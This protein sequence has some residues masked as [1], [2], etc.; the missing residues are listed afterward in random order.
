MENVPLVSF[1][2][3]RSNMSISNKAWYN[4]T[5]KSIF[6][7]IKSKTALHV[8]LLTRLFICLF[9]SVY[10]CLSACLSV[11]WRVYYFLIIILLGFPDIFLRITQSKCY[12]MS[13][14]DFEGKNLLVPYCVET[15]R[16][17]RKGSKA[18]CWK[19]PWLSKPSCPAILFF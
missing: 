3:A 4:A 13:I 10:V 11:C 8:C 1:Y 18:N 19:T 15:S 17:K 6:G 2:F 9:I 14:T 5:E 7:T 12:M 16:K